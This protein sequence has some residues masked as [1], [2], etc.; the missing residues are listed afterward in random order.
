MNPVHNTRR[1]P[2]YGIILFRFC[3]QDVSPSD[4]TFG[5]EIPGETLRRNWLE[6]LRFLREVKKQGSVTLPEVRLLFIGECL[7]GKTS[8]M[9]ALQE[10]SGR[11]GL[12][13]PDNRTVGVEIARDWKPGG[14]DG[15]TIHLWDLAGQKAYLA[16]HSAV[17][18]R[19]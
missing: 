16:G 17:L 6:V 5:V 2:E 14:Q 18:S 7:Q 12:I 19:R 10:E 4:V 13:S 11:T 9:K 1:S 3:L 15:P 8:L